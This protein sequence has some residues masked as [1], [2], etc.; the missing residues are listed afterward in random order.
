MTSLPPHSGLLTASMSRSLQSANV[1]L[2]RYSFLSTF[3]PLSSRERNCFRGFL[4]RW[5]ISG[6]GKHLTSCSPFLFVSY[7][8]LDGQLALLPLGHE[9]RSEGFSLNKSP[10][11][12]RPCTPDAVLCL[13]VVFVHLRARSDF[14]RGF[15]PPVGYSRVCS[16]SPVYLGVSA[17]SVGP[18]VCCPFPLRLGSR[19]FQRAE[20]HRG[21][22][23][24]LAS[25]LSWR[26]SRV[27][28]GERVLCGHG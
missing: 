17:L 20:I 28:R 15:F 23:Y 18:Q 27:P 22:F 13:V 7:R 9:E 26:T 25:G 1:H 24:G 5:L 16:W 10:S 19:L 4:S 8:V 6:V 11:L 14:P 12:P 3:S 21:R 2:S